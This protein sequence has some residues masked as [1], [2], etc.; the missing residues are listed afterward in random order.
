LLIF[1]YPVLEIFPSL[2]FNYPMTAQEKTVLANFFDMARDYLDS[3]FAQKREFYS[4]EDDSALPT[5]MPLVLPEADLRETADFS[6]LPLAYQI[7]E[8]ENS[9]LQGNEADNLNCIDIL[10]AEINSCTACSLGMTRTMA[11][12]GEGS[13]EPLVFIIGEGPGADEDAS[14]RP[15]VGKAGQLLDRMLGSIGLSRERNCYIAN[16]LKC[17]PPNNRDPQSDEIQACTPYL[18]RQIRL[19]RPKLILCAG[20][21]AAQYILRSD[22]GINR[23]RG[24]F[25]KYADGEDGFLPIPVLATYHPSA[26]LHDESLKRPAFEDMKLLM[27]RLAGLDHNYA[28]E[29]KELLQKY[30][31][32]DYEFASLVQ[33]YL[34]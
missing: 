32:A 10:S 16:I 7:D 27:A 21:F 14:G 19:L 5:A 23:L 18:E 12:P 9:N 13:V 1:L 25:G 30:A 8:D 22:E 24:I 15:F 11:V 3:G 31:A 26:L 20:R 4:F 6:S 33:E 34:A 2:G 29:V 17:R 28:R